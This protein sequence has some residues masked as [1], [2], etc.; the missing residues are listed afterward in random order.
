[1]P[2]DPTE[3]EGLCAEVEMTP[4]QCNEVIEDKLTNLLPVLNCTLSTMRRVEDKLANGR[5][6]WRKALQRAKQRFEAQ[7]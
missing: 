4:V 6:D 7:R 1:M 3:R 5:I 2:D